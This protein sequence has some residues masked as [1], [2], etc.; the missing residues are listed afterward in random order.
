MSIQNELINRVQEYLKHDD[1]KLFA[2]M[3]AIDTLT[4]EQLLTY[5]QEQGWDEDDTDEIRAT[6]LMTELPESQ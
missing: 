6:I 2:T 3:S 1:D 5:A 4:E